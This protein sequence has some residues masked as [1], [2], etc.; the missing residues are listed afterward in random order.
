MSLALA[1]LQPKYATAFPAAG[2][3]GII[4]NSSYIGGAV[5]QYGNLSFS[6]I[7]DSGHLVPAYQPETAFTVFTRIIEGTEISTGEPID[8]RSYSSKGNP[9][10]NYTNKVPDQPDNVCW[11]RNIALTCTSD[12]KDQL[13]AG[14]GVVING[15]WYEKESDYNPPSSSII[16]GVPGSLPTNTPTPSISNGGKGSTSSTAQ[17]TGVYIATASPKPTSGASSLRLFSREVRFPN[18]EKYDRLKRLDFSN[19]LSGKMNFDKKDPRRM[20]LWPG[21]ILLLLG[22]WIVL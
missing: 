8:L 15:V 5:R 3:A 18:K 4:V 16:A 1:A 11:I 21:T 7:Y 2:Y 6:R 17:L 10:A 19:Y 9:S 22:V 14:K 13:T 12:Q 20:M